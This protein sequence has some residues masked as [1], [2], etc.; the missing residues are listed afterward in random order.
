MTALTTTKPLPPSPLATRYPKPFPEWII[1]LNTPV[2]DASKN[3]FV[4]P[5]PTEQQAVAIR[6]ARALLLQHLEQT[7]KQFPELWAE[8]LNKLRVLILVKPHSAD[9]G[10][11]R[12]EATIGAFKDATFD[13]PVWAVHRA[14]RNWTIGEVGFYDEPK[15]RYATKWMPDVGE[16]R[17]LAKR[18]VDDVHGR[19]KLLDRLLNEQSVL[20][21][22][23]D[24]DENLGFRSVGEIL[25]LEI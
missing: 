19:I 6:D 17:H 4:C 3:A 5:R 14:I 23:R 24:P 25:K 8:L 9:A 10:A 12:A 2:Y 11:L 7:P 13:L 21:K 16:L 18:Y 15:N 22:P 20:P 1:S